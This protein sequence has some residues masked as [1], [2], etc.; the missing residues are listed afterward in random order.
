MPGV[1]PKGIVQALLATSLCV[2]A[3]ASAPTEDDDRFVFFNW[4]T[5]PGELAALNKMVEVFT[6]HYPGV[7]VV[8][9]VVTGGPATDLRVRLYDEGLKVGKPP[10]SYQVH[11]GA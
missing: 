8:D 10:D 6:D 2:A 4:W 3:C 1:V 9:A 5:S 7:S 11:I